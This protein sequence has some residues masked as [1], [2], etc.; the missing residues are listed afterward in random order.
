MDKQERIN[1]IQEAEQKIVEAIDL[2]KEAV[3]DTP[4]EAGCDAYILGHLK[5]L[6]GNGNPYDHH[7]GKIIEQ[8]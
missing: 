1:L 4:E 3:A 8:L 5:T 7:T 2:I 6:I